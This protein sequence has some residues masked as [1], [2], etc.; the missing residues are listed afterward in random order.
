MTSID[1][2]SREYVNSAEENKAVIRK[3][4]ESY[5]NRNLDIFEELVVPDYIDHTHQT[6]TR[7]EFKRLFTMA[8]EGFPDWYEEIQEMIAE[9][10]RVWVRV[11]ATGTHNGDWNLFGTPLPPTGNKVEM[12]MVFIWRVVDGKMVEGREVDDSVEFLR[13]LGLVEYTK[14]GQK[15]FSEM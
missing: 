1:A 4:I 12:E 7:E 8:F 5:N 3:F 10:D 11:I 9:E 14:K 6:K 15:I 13:K 2:K